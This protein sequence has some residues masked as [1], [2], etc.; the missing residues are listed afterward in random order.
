MRADP[1]PRA[2][3]GST[4]PVAVR[5]PDPGAAAIRTSESPKLHP[6]KRL[7]ELYAY[8]EILAN[9][10]RKEIKVKYT[11]SKLGAAWSM[12]NPLLYLAVFGFVFSVILPTDFPDYTLYLLTG[13]LAWTLFS[14]ALTGASRSVVENANLVKK[15]A[16]PKELLPI[17]SVG[18]AVF[19][20]IL[21]SLVLIVLIAVIQYPVFGA[22]LLL[23]PLAM[24]A[25][26]VFATALSFLVAGL[27][28]RYRDTQHLLNVLLL[29][30]FWL[31][32]VVYPAW[33]LQFQFAVEGPGNWLYYLYLVL[34][35]MAVIIA[36]FQRAIYRFV[37]P[38]EAPEGP[39]GNIL[40]V[41]TLPTLA[42]QLL[43]VIAG[44]LILMYFLWR[45][46][47]RLSGDFAEEL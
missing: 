29:A 30:W 37:H 7:R 8:R 31:T 34:N 11:S 17:S 28:V 16:F 22:N 12:L 13:L 36:G 41:T 2:R 4:P 20:F 25:L 27:N 3:D 1:K 39:E 40:F 32:P 19:D 6:V 43:A 5:T 46:F 26:I 42:L 44:S 9:L 21:Q 24:V 47:F 38:A 35:P 10:T 14:T 23:L 45:Q 33:L 15:V 18:T